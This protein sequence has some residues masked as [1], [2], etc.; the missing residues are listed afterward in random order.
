MYGCE[1]SEDAYVVE[2]DTHV[3]IAIERVIPFGSSCIILHGVVEYNITCD[4]LSSGTDV[5]RKYMKLKRYD[6]HYVQRMKSD[7]GFL[8]TPTFT[9]RE[10]IFFYFSIKPKKAFS[11]FSSW[12]S[13][14]SCMLLSLR[15][16]FLCLK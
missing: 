5:V 4:H 15:Y 10:M 14:W 1:L 9:Y 6:R 2:C 3:D 13:G 11:W 12:C 16:V 8:N 7:H